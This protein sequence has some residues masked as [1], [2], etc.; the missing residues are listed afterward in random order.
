MVTCE[1]DIFCNGTPA[2]S[3]RPR[4]VQHTKIRT[5]ELLQTGE[6]PHNQSLAGA[7][8]HRQGSSTLARRRNF[9]IRTNKLL[10]DGIS[11]R[12]Q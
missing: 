6:I 4:T 9:K 7:P 5:N 11:S 1:D 10:E 12:D 8:S 3:P 2:V